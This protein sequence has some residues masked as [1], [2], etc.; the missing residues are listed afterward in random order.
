MNASP[1]GIREIRLYPYPLSG[2]D[3]ED[4]DGNF[5][6]LNIGT[7]NQGVDTEI[8]QI[9]NGVSDSEIVAEI[10]TSDLTF[11]GEAGAS[12]TYD[13]TG[14][15]GLEA[16]LKDPISSIIGQEIGFFLHNN[17]VLSGSNAIYTITQ[18]RYGRV[19]DIRLT[20]PPN[21]RGFFIQPI[22]YAGGDVVISPDAPSS[23]GLVG[24]LVLVR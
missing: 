10:G 4:G 8:D 17:V 12:V 20:G 13:M 7:G 5:G 1:D 21:Q 3:Y 24:R 16:T 6:V 23:G 9:L 22:S 19:M 18:I 2:N 15:P 14:S 11:F